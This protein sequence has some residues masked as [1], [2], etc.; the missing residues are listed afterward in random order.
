MK[1]S[2]G[3]EP[4]LSLWHTWYMKPCCHSVARSILAHRMCHILSHGITQAV[5]QMTVF[6]A[7]WDNITDLLLGNIEHQTYFTAL[8]IHLLLWRLQY[9]TLLHLPSLFLLPLLAKASISN[10]NIYKKQTMSAAT[11]QLSCSFRRLCSASSFPVGNYLF[12]VVIIILQHA[13]D[14]ISNTSHFHLAG[15]PLLPVVPAIPPTPIPWCRGQRDRT[16]LNGGW[17]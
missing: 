4:P 2:E 9:S 12:P 16:S 3:R 17:R 8:A 14:P 10:T 6:I 5:F 15:S 11:E 1:Y 7:A 13:A